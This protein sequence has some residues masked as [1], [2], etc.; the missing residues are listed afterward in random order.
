MEGK[1]ERRREYKRRERHW[2]NGI[3]RK[4]RNTVAIKNQSCNQT[5]EK[6][7]R[8]DLLGLYWGRFFFTLNQS[9]FLFLSFE[10]TLFVVQLILSQFSNPLS[11]NSLFWVFWAWVHPSFGPRTQIQFSYIY[12][13]IYSWFLKFWVNCFNVFFTTWIIVVLLFEKVLKVRTWFVIWWVL[14]QC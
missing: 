6:Y 7:I 9:I 13:Y 14:I 2:E 10:P 3:E 12:I 8:N 5:C 4:E 1:D 11:I